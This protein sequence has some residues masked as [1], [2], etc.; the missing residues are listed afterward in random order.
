MTHSEHK[1]AASVLRNPSPLTHLM[2]AQ[3]DTRD[4]IEG[5]E[6]ELAV[7]VRRANFLQVGQ[8]RHAQLRSPRC[9]PVP[10]HNRACTN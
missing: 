4:L 6:G 9:P 2:G 5:L 1:P 3:Q 10:G 8:V 7:E